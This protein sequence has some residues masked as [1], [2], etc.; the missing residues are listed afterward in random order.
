[1]CSNLVEK[2]GFSVVI[3]T[4][5]SDKKDYVLDCISSLHKQSFVPNEI[6]LVLDRN[7]AL[8][9]FFRSVVPADIKVVVSDGYGLSHARNAGVKHAKSEIIAFIDDD[10]VADRDWLKNIFENYSDPAVVGVGGIVNPFWGNLKPSTW[11]PEE[12]NWIIG[13]SYKGQSKRKE[14]IRNPLGCNMS[15][16]KS[17]FE[18][19]GYFRPDIGRIGKVLLDGEEPEF[20]MRIFNEIPGAKIYNDPSAK[21]FHKVSSNRLT[22]KY[23]WQRSFYQGFSKGLINDTLRKASKGL[24]LERRYLNYL[25]THSIKSR[26]SK[27][28]VFRNLSQLTMLFISSLMV[29]IG[30]TIGKVRAAVD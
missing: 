15:F 28:N 26:I 8:V 22:F 7:S 25:L 20:S 3:S 5:S 1:M 13:C 4:Y 21:V 12:L 23:L 17:V 6:L 9:N 2:K 19:V 11:F 30:F 29:F 24:S 18:R 27:S 10:A 16:R 14:C